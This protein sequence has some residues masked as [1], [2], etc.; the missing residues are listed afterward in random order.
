M[1]DQLKITTA[2]Q[3]TKIQI[4]EVEEFI[5]AGKPVSTLSSQIGAAKLEK[6]VKAA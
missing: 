6:D 5:T 4:K 2:D 3:I 1:E